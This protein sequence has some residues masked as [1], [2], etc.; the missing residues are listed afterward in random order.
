MK[1]NLFTTLFFILCFGTACG[2]RTKAEIPI[3][4]NAID[5]ARLA[6]RSTV[7]TFA[8]GKVVA[9]VLCQADTTQSYA[10]YL[11]AGG[12]KGIYPVVYFFD[13]HGDGTLP[14]YKYKA[15][16]DAF[17][18][19]LIGSNNSKNG[20]TWA[21]TENSWGILSGDVKKRLK[22][23]ADRIYVCGFSGGAKVATYIALHHQEIKGVIANGAGLQ[24]ISQQNNLP[25]SFT[26][27]TCEGDMNR[28]DLID[29]D[30]ALDKTQ[31]KH[32]IVFFDGIH[33]WAPE[34]SMKIAFS[35][36]QLDAM[37]KKTIATDAIF[38]NQYINQ[39]KQEIERL[40]KANQLIRAAEMCKLSAGMLDGLTS[41][42][43]WFQKKYT[44]FAESVAY[45]SQLKTEQDLLAQEENRKAIFAQHFQQGDRSYWVKAIADLKIK[46]GTKSVETA[47]YQRLQAYLSLAFYSFNNRLITSGDVKEAAYFV[48]LYKMADPTNSEAW[49]FSAVLNAQNNNAI[50][51]T[52]DL[53]KAVAYGFNN[54]QRLAQQPEF[55]QLRTQINLNEIISKIH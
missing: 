38:I 51:T 16:A 55:K 26:A 29:I 19:A 28:S 35:G 32:R 20:N 41:E 3:A 22:V 13:P 40:A 8:T 52:S 34:K 17:G 6:T 25:F 46:A 31:T 15:L 43:Q 21:D 50:A 10:L 53:L 54:K 11:P 42:V 48:D 47:M 23:N 1:I 2:G 36:F 4:V 12:N 24:E 18:F 39:S 49:Y 30:N 37:N 27:I 7:D 45:K 33:E 44:L 5:T 14:L 9:R